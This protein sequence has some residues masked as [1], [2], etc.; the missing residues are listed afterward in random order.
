[1]SVRDP[2]DP[3]SPGA[4][5][6]HGENLAGR[7][8]ARARVTR[9]DP[10]STGGAGACLAGRERVSARDPQ[11]P[12]STRRWNVTRLVLGRTRVRERA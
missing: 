8:H 7:E 11:N 5:E 10:G 6:H 12:G 2:Q 3:G 1:M 9:R 4:L